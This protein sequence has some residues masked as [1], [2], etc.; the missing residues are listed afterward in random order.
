MKY[1]DNVDVTTLITYGQTFR[2]G[3]SH[4]YGRFEGSINGQLLLA[5]SSGAASLGLETGFFQVVA[6]TYSNV[7]GKQEIINY[8][9]D[10]IFTIGHDTD[11]FGL[12]TA[13][14]VMAETVKVTVATGEPPFE[15]SSA[16]MVNNL[17]VDM[18]DGL[19]GDYYLDYNNLTNKPTLLQG[20]I[21]PP[22]PAGAAGQN[23]TNG[24]NGI[25]GIP[26]IP[27]VPGPPGAPGAAGLPG[28]S[29]SSGSDG[30]DGAKGDKGDKGDTGAAG[31]AVNPNW[32]ETDTTKPAYIQNKPSVIQS[33][34]NQQTTTSIDFIKNKPTFLSRW[35][36]DPNDANS[37]YYQTTAGRVGIGKS[38]AS[39]FKLDVDGQVRGTIFTST[40]TDVSPFQVSSLIRVDNLNASLLDG[41]GIG[42]FMRT[43][44]ST[45]TSWS[46]TTTSTVTCKQLL[47]TTTI[48]P[49]FVVSSTLKVINLN[50]ELL[51]GLD[52]TAFMRSDANTATSGTL[53][54]TR[55]ISTIATGTAPLTVTSTTKVANLNA[56]LLDDLDSTK[57]MRADGA[58]STTGTLTGTR[59]IS[60][61]ATGT[62]PL[63]V[64]ST[65]L[66]TNLN[67]ALFN[68][69]NAA[70]YLSYANLTGVPAT[71]SSQ[72]TTSGTF[73]YYNTGN[74]GIGIAT[75]AAKLHVVGAILATADVTAYYSDRRLK[76]DVREITSAL[77]KLSKIRGVYYTQNELAETFG[78]HNYEPQVGVIAQELQTVL[79]EAVK[80]APFDTN[81]E[82]GSISGENYLTVQYHKIVPLL[83]QAIKEQQEEINDLRRMVLKK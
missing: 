9:I 28:S 63:T 4:F 55:L 32:N 69:Q 75:P 6:H 44:T 23:G 47:S 34:W 14:D 71:T 16:T 52:S 35:W 15:I 68:G 29:G 74:V 64:T 19:H 20:E 66:V 59:L 11:V 22:G 26:G 72:W 48:V 77:D 83:I 41:L 79:P 40:V 54:G 43:D 42:S 38:P 21:G 67:V 3:F 2:L 45:S 50:A 24:T 82:Q 51:D 31:S 33:D 53:T 17:N 39:G 46:I 62:A 7:Y 12:L 13:T 36:A 10:P 70:Y 1:V 37:I 73:I 5:G 76:K 25:P 56:D 49:P 80:L 30:S 81:A 65:T 8:G 18:L 60:T 58:T 57:F 27:G 78:Y 61:I